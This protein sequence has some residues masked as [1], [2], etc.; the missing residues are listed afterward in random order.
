MPLLEMR[1][2]A[3]IITEELEL[4]AWGTIDPF[5]IRVVADGYAHNAPQSE[6]VER[7]LLRVTARINEEIKRDARNADEAEERGG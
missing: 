5:W 6:D 3:Q 1:K 7:V 4:D 2:L